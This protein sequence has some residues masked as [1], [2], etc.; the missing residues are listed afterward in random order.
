MAL[1]I[2]AIWESVKGKIG[3]RSDSL[4]ISERTLTPIFRIGYGWS[5][6]G[7]GVSDRRCP[8]QAPQDLQSGDIATYL[9]FQ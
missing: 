5:P 6:G 1:R 4:W 8:A 9:I 3:D 7:I 2:G